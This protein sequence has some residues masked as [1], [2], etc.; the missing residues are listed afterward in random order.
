MA[1]AGNQLTATQFHQW[2][3]MPSQAGPRR[4]ADNR[5]RTS[6]CFKVLRAS[7]RISNTGRSLTNQ[8]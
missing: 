7:E 5:V 8:C 2:P 6:T 4:L 3:L 1:I